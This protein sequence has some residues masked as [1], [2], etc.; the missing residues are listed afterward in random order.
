MPLEEIRAEERLPTVE[1]F[2]DQAALLSMV[3]LVASTN[4]C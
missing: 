1:E 4:V 2:A 3:S